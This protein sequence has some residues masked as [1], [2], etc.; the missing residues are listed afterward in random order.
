MYLQANIEIFLHLYFIYWQFIL[1]ILSLSSIVH[2]ENVNIKIV[3][4]KGLKII[5]SNYIHKYNYSLS[6]FHI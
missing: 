4:A 3:E 1:Q 6:L 2:V 5:V